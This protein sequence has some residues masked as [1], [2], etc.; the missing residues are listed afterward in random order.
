M[1]KKA[2]RLAPFAPA[3]FYYHLGVA[4]L[5]TGQCDEAISACEEALRR[6]SNNPSAH[7]SATA[8]YS[9]CG[10][11]EEARAAAA[12]VLRINPNFSC[13]YYAKK[14]LPYKNQADIDLIIG[15]LRKAG[16]K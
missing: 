11:E 12:E 13:D 6:G 14:A 3:K 9:M 8:A 1:F 16:L 15:A 4:Y 7:R 5:L 10:R 2:I